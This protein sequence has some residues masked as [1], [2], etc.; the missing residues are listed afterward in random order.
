MRRYNPA[1]SSNVMQKEMG[2]AIQ[3]A[4]TVKGTI[5][6]SGILTALLFAGAFWS[7]NQI[8]GQGEMAMAYA[9]KYTMISA[10]AGLV[11]AMLTIFLRK[12]AAFLAPLYAIVE[13]FFLGSISLVFESMY[14]GIVFQAILGTLSVFAVMLFLYDRKI[15]VVTN[16]LRSIVF[17]ATGAIFLMYLAS[18]IMGFFGMS[19]GFLHDSGPLGI[20]ISLLIIGVAAFNLLLDFDMIEQYAGRVDKHM[21]WYCGFALLVTLVWLYMEILRLLAKT[22]D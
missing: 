3:D 22:R 7:W 14:P 15:I 1:M 13:G 20:G 9:Q 12:Y 4:M 2:V 19:M 5:H 6:K 16:K 11:L 10:I 21:E 18:W 8:A 17:A